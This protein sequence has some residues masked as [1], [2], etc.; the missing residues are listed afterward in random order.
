MH[1]FVNFAALAFVCLLNVNCA[2]NETEE[3]T[4]SVSV[5]SLKFSGDEETKT[6]SVTANTSW[7]A[8]CPDWWTW[9]C[10][11]WTAR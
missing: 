1:P 7:S 6:I 3:E 10:L 4:V 8:E 2:N 5:A 11:R 9:P